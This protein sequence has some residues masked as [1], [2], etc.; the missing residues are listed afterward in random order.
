MG[1][2]PFIGG[3]GTS[4]E[5]KVARAEI[6]A[7]K[8][9]ETLNS[10][11]DVE[12]ALDN[13][14]N[15]TD[16]LSL[17]ANK[18][19]KTG[20]A[21]KA[22]A[23]SDGNNIITT[24]AK[25]TDLDDIAC[26]YRGTYTTAEEL[27]AAS[28]DKN[29]FA[30]LKT[31]DSA[32]NEIY[33]RYR[34]V[35]IPQV[36]PE[37]Y[38]QLMYIT[39]NGT[40]YID[41]GVQAKRDL[42]SYIK[43]TRKNGGNNQFFGVNES[44]HNYTLYFSDWRWQLWCS[45]GKSSV[46]VSSAS[47]GVTEYLINYPTVTVND[48]VFNLSTQ[49]DFT[50]EK[51]IYLCAVN[52]ESNKSII[53]LYECIIYDDDK[54]TELKHFYPCK[55][56][57]N[58][59]GMYETVE[60]VF[61]PDANG[62]SFAAGPQANGY[63]NFE[64]SI[65][66]NLFSSTQFAALN[67]GINT[68]KVK[69]IET[70][71][72]NIAGIK[73][74]TNIDSFSDVEAALSN[75]VDKETGKGL[76]TNDYTTAEKTKLAGIAEGAEVNEIEGIKV[77]NTSVNPDA[78]KVVNITIPTTAADVSALPDTTKYATAI[79]LE[80]N[81]STYVVTCQLKDQNGDNLGTAQ[82]IDLPLES[83]VVGGSYASE[84]QKVVLTLQNG[85]TVEFSVADLVSGL[86]TEL[87]ETNKLNPAYINYDSTHRAVSDAEKSA[88]NAKQ[89]ALTTEQLAAVNS[90]ITSA[91]V[92]Q[93]NTNASILS[94]TYNSAD[95][96]MSVYLYQ[97]N[98][99]ID[100]S[101]YYIADQS[102]MHFKIRQFR[103]LLRYWKDGVE[104]QKYYWTS[105]GIIATNNSAKKDMLTLDI[106]EVTN[107]TYV[108][109]Q[110][111]TDDDSMQTSIGFAWQKSS[112]NVGDVWYIRP[113]IEYTDL[114]T[115]MEYTMYGAV[116]KVTAGVPCTIECDTL[117]CTELTAREQA[118]KNNI[119]T[120]E[121]ALVELVDGGTKN[122]LDYVGFSNSNAAGINPFTTKSVTYKK[123]TDGTISTYTTNAGASGNAFCYLC[124][125]SGIINLKGYFDGKHI[126][127]CGTY[128]A[129]HYALFYKIDSEASVAVN[130]DILLP[131]RND[132][133]A[134]CIIV[135]VYSG[136]IISES[137]PI[138]FNPMI[139]TKAAWDISQTYQPY[140]PNVLDSKMTRKQAITN[141]IYLVERQPKATTNPNTGAPYIYA[142]FAHY[143]YD[144]DSVEGITLTQ[145]GII[146]CNDG[147][148]KVD[149]LR[150]EN[151]DG[152][153]IIKKDNFGGTNL[154]VSGTN[155][156]TAVGFTQ[157]Q[158]ADGVMSDVLYTNDIGGDY[159][160]LNAPDDIVAL[161]QTIG[162]INSV[163]EEVL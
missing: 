18:L 34:R 102:K 38:T 49:S 141:G 42:K 47:S 148:A 90:G 103:R 5:D 28:G 24:Y 99:A 33:S 108:K 139:C 53:D 96:N 66:G 116:Y 155:P 7:I 83:V 12:T 45:I 22:T 29:D 79:R 30:F 133:T 87:S 62:G 4:S 132:I 32:G 121:A 125:D 41:T 14:A 112:V 120:D 105:M 157:Y 123:N 71:K 46:D 65:P 58:V 124:D 143:N 76:S 15:T 80:I 104:Y 153:H 109:I 27:N 146:Y 68:T 17:D 10:F 35:E 92:E 72:N 135:Q 16:I 147:T 100:N 107:E 142:S 149:D 26:T 60:G 78:N 117:S 136:E 137:N 13:K 64:Y 51:T 50:S 140:K 130:G 63:W 31:T 152:I 95:C 156:V 11:S 101:T 110:P 54:T 129:N 56:S 20:T 161:Q 151:V 52:G 74:G 88:W 82:T 138:I 67:S 91:D 2:N 162:D 128:S 118:N 97:D 9:G 1:F 57:S 126:L 144:F 106:P 94:Q 21:V 59:C 25:K 93:I 55:N 98:G 163:L 81:S 23:D 114:E 145:F 159:R 6:A 44:G 111:I 40:Q 70:N 150:L 61:Y 19:D 73:D 3:G 89:S 160:M 8:D 75:K 43:F 37:G 113:Y 154:P 115:G 158:D 85:N 122:L 131:N 39:S 69:Q 36:V 119:S 84:T 127:S 77:N 86:Q 48:T 134:A